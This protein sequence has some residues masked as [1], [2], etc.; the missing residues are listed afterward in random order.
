MIESLGW[1]TIQQLINTQWFCT[2][3]LFPFGLL[4]NNELANLYDCNF[5]FWVDTIPSFEIT[6]D[7]VNLPY[8]DDYDIDEHILSNVN[9][10]YHTLQDLLLSLH[11]DEILSTLAILKIIFDVIGV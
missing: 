5:P 11:F 8:L 1:K 10:S 6:S 7:L 4:D 9:S 2:T 3:V